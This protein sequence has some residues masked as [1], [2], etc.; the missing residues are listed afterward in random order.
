[1]LFRMSLRGLGEIA[2]FEIIQDGDL[3]V[4]P[5]GMVAPPEIDESAILTMPAGE[6][7]EGLTVANA[8]PAV[9]NELG[10][11]PSVTGVIVLNPGPKAGRVGLRPGD[12]LLEINNEEIVS[13]E[14]I[15]AA[16]DKSNR[17]VKIQAQRGNQSLTLRF[18]L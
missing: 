10:M 17:R 1:M 12:I 13:V 9:L 4:K 3:V 2:E 16:L 18:G 11:P 5:V 6:K 15:A 7:L 14:D 8:T